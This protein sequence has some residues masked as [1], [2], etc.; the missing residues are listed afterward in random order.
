MSIPRR[1]VQTR[2]LGLQ[3]GSLVSN[4]DTDMAAKNN[5]IDTNAP[6]ETLTDNPFG[7]LGGLRES[8]PLRAAE[9]ERPKAEILEDLPKVA[10][11]VART[12][13][14]GWPVTYERRPGGKF[15]TLIQQ[16]T[17]DG[18]A[19]ATALKKH[20]ASGGA[21]K[22]GVVELQGDHREKVTAYLNKFLARG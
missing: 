8:L 21:F 16:V 20:C 2:A 3:C 19:L 11:R 1:L 14:G 10:W 6:R 12:K 18:D 9:P 15:A 5:R 22:D 4:L 17:G 13:K 7:A